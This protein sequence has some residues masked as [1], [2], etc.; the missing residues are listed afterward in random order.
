MTTNLGFG[1]KLGAIKP[2]VEPQAPI[3]DK[4]VDEVAKQHGFVSREPVVRVE[5][6]RKKNQIQDTLYVRGPIEL[7]NK[8]KEFCNEAG[9]SYGEGL[10]ALM[11][12]AKI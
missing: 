6:N 11:K 3:D 5:K 12:K 9:Y 4:K 7:T 10:E 2:D 1:A 8:F